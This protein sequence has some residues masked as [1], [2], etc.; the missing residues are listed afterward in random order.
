MKLKNIQVV[1]NEMTKYCNIEFKNDRRKEIVNVKNNAIERALTAVGMQGEGY[2][3]IK[4]PVQT[5]L[6]R[7]SITFAVNGSSPN[8]TSYSANK[9][10]SKNGE[11][12]TGSY[13]GNF[14]N[15]KDSTNQSVYIGTNVEYATF[16]EFGTSKRKAKPFLKPAASEHA[17]E[18]KAIF[19][20]VLHD[21][22]K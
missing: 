3:K 4:C 18:Y 9:P 5:G 10:S 22:I 14:S 19:K 1:F 11:V 15:S 20:K 12:K 2:A 13:E 6:L 8:A 21:N 7:N 16:V 17:D